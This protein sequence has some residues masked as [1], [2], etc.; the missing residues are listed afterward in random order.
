M[1]HAAL[2]I[3]FG[4][5][6]APSG[7]LVRWIHAGFGIF[8]SVPS[9]QAPQD[10]WGITLALALIIKE[11]PF[12]IITGSIAMRQIQPMAYIHAAQS[13]GYSYGAA[14][15]KIVLPLLYRQMRLPIF[16][17]LAYSISVADMAIILGPTVPPTFILRLLQWANDPDLSYRFVAA[18]GAIFHAGF[19]WAN[20]A[21]WQGLVSGFA[22]IAR[23]FLSNG[24]RELPLHLDFFLIII[25]AMAAILILIFAF[26][27]LFNLLL[28]SFA[29]QWVYPDLF[30]M[31]DFRIWEKGFLIIPSILETSLWIASIAIGFSLILTLACLEFGQKEK[32]LKMVYAPLIIPEFLLVFGIT[33]LMIFFHGDGHILAVAWLHVLFVFPYLYLSIREAWYQLDW[34][35]LRSAASLGA[36]RWR[37]FFHVKLPL[38]RGPI[39]NAMA[40]GFAVSFTLY[41]PTLL[42]GAGRI[43]TLA[44]EAVQ[45]SAAGDRRVMAMFALTQSMAI[46]V[47]FLIAHFFGKSR[48]EQR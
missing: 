46:W 37:I 30:P 1:P 14:W 35:Y 25:L 23:P 2:A 8:S 13:L 32:G 36:G 48:Y 3:G 21:L 47:A 22:K 20:L 18:A 11:T 43:N 40:I 12:L 28:W 17:V 29:W 6:I 33:I 45:L 7:W 16:A 39:F 26:G 10:P 42:M 19:V 34:R 27:G 9:Y 38:L 24:R 15:C 31:I 4:F 5:L 41:L 44:T